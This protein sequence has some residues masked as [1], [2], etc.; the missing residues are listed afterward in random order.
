MTQ[1]L[2]KQTGDFTY[3]K[4]VLSGTCEASGNNNVCMLTIP[5]NEGLT[6]KVNGHKVELKRVLSDFVAFELDE[7]HNNIKVTFIPPGFILASILSVLALACTIAYIILV[8]KNKLTNNDKL[9]NLSEIIVKLGVLAAIAVV[10]LIPI[11]LNLN[12]VPPEV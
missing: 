4:G 7:G 10:Y 12:Y 6:V 5:Y 11:L 2:R 3:K 8:K 9:N 1:S